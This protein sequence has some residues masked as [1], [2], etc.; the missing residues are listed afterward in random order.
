MAHVGEAA[1]AVFEPARLHHVEVELRRLVQS[2]LGVGLEPGRQAE[3]LH[4]APAGVGRGQRGRVEGGE[5]VGAPAGEA[6]L[7]GRH[8][9]RVDP[10][11]RFG[12]CWSR[13]AA[14]SGSDTSRCWT[15]SARKADVESSR[16]V[17]QVGDD[18]SPP[19][20]PPALRRPSRNASSMPVPVIAA[21][22]R[23]RRRRGS[24]SG[25]PSATAAARRVASSRIRIAARPADVPSRSARGA[26][27]C[28]RPAPRATGPRPPRSRGGL[29][30]RA[31]RRRR[32]P[33]PH[34]QDLGLA[35]PL[36]G[37]VVRSPR[38]PSSS[39]KARVRPPR[40]RRRPAASRSRDR[41][42]APGSSGSSTP[43]PAHHCS[44]R[45]HCRHCRVLTSSATCSASPAS[46]TTTSRSPSSC[47][48]MAAVTAATACAWGTC[49]S[50][51]QRRT[52]S[53]IRHASVVSPVS[54]QANAVATAG[55]GQSHQ[56]DR[57]HRR[58]S[59][60]AR[61]EREPARGVG[62]HGSAPGRRGSCPARSAS[63]PRRSKSAAGPSRRRAPRPPPAPRRR[64]LLMVWY[65]AL[66]CHHGT[67]TM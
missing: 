24:G 50:V 3:D 39:A 29:V 62:R 36:A 37:G 65:S 7:A 45:A 44:E 33:R 13:Y 34:P 35:E 25:P 9:V 30:D 67:S 14:R 60:Q 28:A 55:S 12:A 57:G 6:L 43:S 5:H 11:R 48:M 66:A 63:W 53:A 8:P 61:L 1:R 18:L 23:A 26:P 49:R 21:P 56:L 20:G 22:G 54:Q 10:R 32:R 40:G 27:A 15:T 47:A 19:R 16:A 41:A 17:E 46:L 4:A 59:A 51:V 52:S 31:P 64:I 38:R 2:A 58:Q 42:A